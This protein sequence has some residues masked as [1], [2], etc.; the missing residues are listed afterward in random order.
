MR[1]ELFVQIPTKSFTSSDISNPKG[2]AAKQVTVCFKS[3]PDAFLI[4]A[5]EKQKGPLYF[6]GK[7]ILV[8]V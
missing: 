5:D 4:E 1:S 3:L 8:H 6:P 2:V 7:T